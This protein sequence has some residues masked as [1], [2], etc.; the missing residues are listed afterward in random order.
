ML[1]KQHTDQQ[2]KDLADTYAE[3]LLATSE[4]DHDYEAV[5]ER[6]DRIQKELA[7]RGFWP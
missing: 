7:S 2:L 4:V 3:R 5:A 6:F 1:L